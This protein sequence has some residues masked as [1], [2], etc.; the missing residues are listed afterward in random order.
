MKELR[1]PVYVIVNHASDDIHRALAVGR[2]CIEGG[3]GLIQF[4]AKQEL[5]PADL[6]ALGALTD[7]SQS[8]GVPMI[9]NDLPGLAAQVGAEGVHVGQADVAAAKAREVLGPD[10]ILGVTAP[11]TGEAQ[12]AERDGASYVAVGAMHPS[13]TKSERP[14][15]GPERLREVVAAVSIPVCAIGGITPARVGA[16]LDSGAELLCVISAVSRADNPLQAVKDLVRAC[17]E[18]NA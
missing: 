18:H 16:M 2:A 1:S 4:R 3:A 10:A 11:T 5:G 9:V 17:D 12:A 8:A 6:N 14:V 13:P 7:E 15:V